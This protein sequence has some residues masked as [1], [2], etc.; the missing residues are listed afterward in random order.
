MSDSYGRWQPRLH[1]LA[2]AVAAQQ[3]LVHAD[4]LFKDHYLEAQGSY[5]PTMAVCIAQIEPGQLHFNG[6]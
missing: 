6:L 2:E 3:G 5:S 4:D 1:A